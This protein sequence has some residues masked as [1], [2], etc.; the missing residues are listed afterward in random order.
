[1][2]TTFED[3]LL[4]LCTKNELIICDYD[5]YGRTSNQFTYIS[6]AHS[7][8]SWLDHIICSLDF[9]S[10]ASGVVI[11]DKLPSSDY[12]PVC[13]RIRF[14]LVFD[15]ESRDSCDGDV[16]IPSMSYHWSKASDAKIEQDRRIG[17]HIRDGFTKRQMRQAPRAPST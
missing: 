7:T 5:K 6:N 4:E 3:E 1:M 11:L 8:T 9:C 16:K 14:K 2:G 13:C 10:L 12:L 15:V 17:S